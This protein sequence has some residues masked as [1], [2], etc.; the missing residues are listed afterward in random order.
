MLA[1]LNNYQRPV[2][3][4]SKGSLR[5]TTDDGGLVID[6]DLPDPADND[7]TRV[8]LEVADS[9]GIYAR[10][11]LD[12]NRSE[13][14]EQGELRTYSKAWVRAIIIAATDL[15][16]G[17]DEAEIAEIVEPRRAD[18][19]AERRHHRDRERIRAERAQRSRR[20]WL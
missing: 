4:T 5:F 15:H 19:E 18:P 16:D 2:A 13:Y 14:A 20:P 10:P 11:Y 1:V 6:V 9:V 7:T 12:Q 8:I 17:L 3:A